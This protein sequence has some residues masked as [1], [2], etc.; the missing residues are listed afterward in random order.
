MPKFETP[1][2]IAI[3]VDVIL[4][5]V[6]IIASDRA[7]TVVEVRPS[8]P[9][10]KDDV[11]AAQET[12]VDFVAGHLT[13][14]EPRGWKMYTPVQ[15]RPVDRRDHRGAHRLPAAR[16]RQ[17]VPVPGHR[18]ARPVRTEDVRRRPA[19]GGR[20][21]HLSAGRRSAAHPTTPRHFPDRA[22]PWAR[23][24]EGGRLGLSIWGI[25]ELSGEGVAPIPRAPGTARIAGLRSAH[26][27][28]DHR[29]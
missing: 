10:K 3:T 1:Q 14:K 18:R 6:K 29:P 13:V 23:P 19:A 17:H 2:P 12:E 25:R 27:L 5:D 21:R 9:S 7:D 24:P 22:G 16:H 15:R 4:G 20:P 26:A 28:R 11:R 8:D